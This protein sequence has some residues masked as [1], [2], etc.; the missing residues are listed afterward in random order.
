MGPV[1]V[2]VV[3]Q[4]REEQATAGRWQ[5]LVSCWS[6]EAQDDNRVPC[7]CQIADAKGTGQAFE[8]TVF[9]VVRDDVGLYPIWLGRNGR[10]A[11]QNFHGDLAE[12]LI[13]DRATIIR[14]TG[15]TIDGPHG[16]PPRPKE[17]S[18]DVIIPIA[19]KNP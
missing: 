3:A 14:Q 11:G 2:F 13:Y 9:D 10:H 16:D 17:P 15:Q 5:R 19:A 8:P 4:R 7:F 1:A 12:V 6:G 18:N